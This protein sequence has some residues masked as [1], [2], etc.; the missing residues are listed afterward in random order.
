VVVVEEEEEEEEE[1][2]AS[3]YGKRVARNGDWSETWQH[4]TRQSGGEF[5]ISTKPSWW[6]MMT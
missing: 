6:Q 2:C 5:D 4:N 3:I 1:V